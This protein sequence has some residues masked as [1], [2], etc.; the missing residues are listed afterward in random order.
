MIL[1]FFT[2]AILAIVT[3]AL[4]FK[5][6]LRKRTIVAVLVF[7]FLSAAMTLSVSTIDDRASPGD[8]RY[9]PR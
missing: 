3:F 5:L 4:T 8:Q 6:S 9:N 2:A 7:V 1:W